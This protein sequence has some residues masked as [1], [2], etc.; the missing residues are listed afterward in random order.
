[1]AARSLPEI[2]TSGSY[3]RAWLRL[4][5]LAGLTVAAMVVPQA[6]AYAELG[7]LEPSAGFRAILVAL[8]IY[9]LLGTSR[10][11]GVGP[12][13]GTAVLAAL[14]V[15]PLAGGDPDRYLALMAALAGMVGV[16][17][18]LGGLLRLGFVANLL[19]KPVLVGYI[20]GVGLTLLSSQLSSFT[21]VPIDADAFF[22]RFG[23]F[24]SR[25]DQI[26][27]ATIGVGLATLAIILGLRRW[28]P[29]LPGALIGLAVTIAAV[30]IFGLDVAL[31]GQ[32]D[33]ALAD[34]RRT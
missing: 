31:V 13:P 22:G 26:D 24:F 12:E 16:L 6:M 7:G 10:H 3:E 1:M 28:R 34:P 27:G 30:A 8:P 21:G 32:V 23:E 9:A 4:D 29:A 20:T 2:L 33:A 17:G 11:L 15:A 14:A 18:L 19:S 25:F 5:A